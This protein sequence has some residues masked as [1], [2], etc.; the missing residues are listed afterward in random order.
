MTNIGWGAFEGCSSLTSINIPKAVKSIENATFANCSK[1]TSVNIHEAVT[2][3]GATA[4]QG[5]SALA[6]INIPNSVTEIGGSA[7]DGTAWFDN[8][9]DGLIYIG[10]FLYKLK[11]SCQNTQ[12][13][14]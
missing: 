9:P 12:I 8:Q 5:C 13:L 11:G 3:I 7:F 2:K 6:S 14:S 10:T 4:F 1:L